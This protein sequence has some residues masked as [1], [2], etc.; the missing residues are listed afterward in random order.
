MDTT[1]DTERVADR[2]VSPRMLIP[3]G[4][5]LRVRVDVDP[6]GN[7]AIRIDR[8]HGSAAGNHK[9]NHGFPNHPGYSQYNR[10]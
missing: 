1:P 7:R 4:A 8:Y 3:E 2:A 5:E 10:S 6:D 9:H